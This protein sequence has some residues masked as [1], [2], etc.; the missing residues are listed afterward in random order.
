MSSQIIQSGA[1][2]NYDDFNMPIPI[3]QK[4]ISLFWQ[5]FN[6]KSNLRVRYPFIVN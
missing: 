4:I 3:S 5:L 1:Y 2:D 6:D